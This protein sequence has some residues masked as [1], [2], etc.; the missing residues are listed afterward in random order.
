MNHPTIS[1]CMIVKDEEK[2]ILNCLESVKEFIDEII[3]VDT[4]STDQ[5]VAICQAFNAKIFH[6]KWNNSFAEARNFGLE[7]ATGDWILWLDADE[8]MDL[9]DAKE[10]KNFLN[11]S[12][13][14]KLISIHLINYIGKEND[15]NQTFH[16]AHTRL[17]KNYEGFKF[18]Y[19]IHET[20][21][22]EEILGEVQEIKTLPVKV[23]HYGYLD[24]EVSRKQKTVR[25]LTLLKEE[26]KKEKHS[27]WIE[28]H[29]ASEYYKEK[30]TQMPLSLLI[31]P[32]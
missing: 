24:S 30:N 18:I 25:N 14:E 20:L 19:N 8:K 22:V 3:I 17:F 13:D 26:L 12:K 28:Y 1:L 15:I 23:F 5:T 10:L 29:I 32:Y 21:N 6:F 2:N 4:G 7:Q 27:P 9:K 16:I 11:Q 31:N